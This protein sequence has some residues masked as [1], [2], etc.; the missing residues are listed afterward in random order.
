MREGAD[1]IDEFPELF[2][3]FGIVVGGHLAAVSAL[4]FIHDVVEFAVGELGLRGRIAP[5]V[6]VHIDVSGF[7]AFSIA[8]HAV[9]DNAVGTSI[10]FFALID[11]GRSNWNRIF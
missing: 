3:R 8:I 9:A 7:E 5:I 4:A 2:W 1:V 6:Q 10:P 11:R